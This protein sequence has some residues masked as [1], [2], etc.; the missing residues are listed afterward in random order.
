[1]STENSKDIVTDTSNSYYIHHLDQLENL[2]VP[3]K[4]NGS[5]YATWSKSMTHALIANN[6]I[7]FIDG[8]ISA[9]SET[10]QPTKYA[11]WNQCNSMLFSWLTHSLEADL[12]KGIVHTKSAHHVWEDLKD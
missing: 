3:E 9:P 5:N 7:G 2:L 11:I 1:M 6:K 10:K 8:T 12:A 4:L